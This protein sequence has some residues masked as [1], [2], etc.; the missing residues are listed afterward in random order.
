MTADELKEAAKKGR[1]SPFGRLV[2]S[3]SVETEKGRI[4][5]EYQRCYSQTDTRSWFATRFYIIR[6]GKK[7]RAR[8]TAAQ[9]RRI[10]G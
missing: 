8:L 1:L 3:A 2:H 10:L 4:I 5:C 9:A 6:P 7:Y